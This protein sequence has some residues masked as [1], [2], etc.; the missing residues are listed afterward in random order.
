MREVY[1]AAGENHGALGAPADGLRTLDPTGPECFGQRATNRAMLEAAAVQFRI[2]GQQVTLGLDSRVVGWIIPTVAHETGEVPVPTRLKN[3]FRL[4]M[5]RIVSLTRLL[6]KE[7]PEGTE[8]ADGRFGSFLGAKPNGEYASGA[9]WPRTSIR[10]CH[11]H[12]RRTRCPRRGSGRMALARVFHQGHSADWCRTSS[13]DGLEALRARASDVS[14]D[15]PT[16]AAACEVCSEFAL[17]HLRVGT[18]SGSYDTSAEPLCHY[19][20]GGPYLYQPGP[21]EPEALAR[22]WCG[23]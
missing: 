22:T 17:R 19:L 3:Q 16:R 14:L 12:R 15:E 23:C 21:G 4:E 11:G 2:V 5:Q 20:S 7:R 13:S 1:A 8:L 9:C 18:G 10:R 6:A